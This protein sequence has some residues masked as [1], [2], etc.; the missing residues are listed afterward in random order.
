MEFTIIQGFALVFAFFALS[1]VILRFK[2]RSITLR[3]LVFWSVIWIAI[4][5]TAFIPEVSRSIAN[6][7]GIG[8]GVD[9]LIYVSIIVLFYLLFRLYVKIDSTDQEITKLVRQVS[10]KDIKKKKK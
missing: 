10:L 1:R 2:D 4:I 6:L 3:E 9:F 8:R 7:F 5:V